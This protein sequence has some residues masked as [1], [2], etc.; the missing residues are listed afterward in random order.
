[1]TKKSKSAKRRRQA[2]GVF[3]LFS[4]SK[5]TQKADFILLFTVFIL[6]IF[7][8]I[9]VYNA[10]IVEASQNFADRFYYLRYQGAYFI[11]GWI[12][13]I[14]AG[15]ID[16]HVYKKIIRYLFIVNII[17]LIMVF[18]PGISPKIYGA[19]RWI[20]LGPITFQPTEPFKTILVVYLA[21]WLE[22]KRT[23]IQ[24]FA[25]L[26]VVVGLVMLQ[27]DL[28]TSIVLVASS[29]LVYYISGAP[30]VKF[31]LS[32]MA[33][34]LT[35]LLLILAS[36]YRRQRLL[37]FIDSKADPQGTSYHI[38]QIL[39]ALGSGG[40]F[41]LGIGQSKQKYQ[42]LPEATSDSIFAIIGEEVGFVG[43]TI[44]IC[45][46][47][48][49]IWKGF[50]IA[51]R[52]PDMFGRLLATG[53][54]GWIGIQVFVNLSSMVSLAPLTGIPLPL[55]SYGGT[56]LVVTLVSIGILLNISKQRVKN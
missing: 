2:S 4:K 6:T 49:I 5:N 1:M 54:T 53:I 47:M 15:H 31:A 17:L 22:H 41:G 42:Y 14:L 44:L 7:G 33:A 34:M 8:L 21:T 51:Q 48:V 38:Q 28:G 10:S 35:G 39:I 55:M 30:V 29:F 26:V 23:V 32:T 40:I 24:F 45:F 18:I 11:L 52:A 20:D 36:P 37:T 19:R 13:L 27:P 43:A 56:S 50:Q 9:M 3:T 25:L 12:G 46:Y 16:Y